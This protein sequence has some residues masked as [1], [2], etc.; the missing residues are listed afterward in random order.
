MAIMQANGSMK[1]RRRRPASTARAMRVVA[2]QAW[3]DMAGDDV[4]ILR[5]AGIYGPGRNALA[6]LRA[7][8]ARRIIKPGQV[9]NRIHVDD[10]ASAIMAAVHHPSGGIWERLRRRA[11]TAA[12]RDRLCRAAHGHCAAA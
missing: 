8:T 10:I 6:T 11:R 5:L 3:T 12:G 4:A 1:A 7:G 2:E 9:F